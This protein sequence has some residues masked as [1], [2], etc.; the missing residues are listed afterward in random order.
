MARERKARS[1]S[2]LVQPDRLAEAAARYIDWEALAYWAR[3]ALER[4]V[5]CLRRLFASLSA[6]ARG[7]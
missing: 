3:P 2:K 7:L 1:S 4:H 6:D 5:D